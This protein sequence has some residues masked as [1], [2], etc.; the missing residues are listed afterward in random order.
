[1]PIIQS[2]LGVL[3]INR[4]NRRVGIRAIEVCFYELKTFWSFGLY[5]LRSKAGIENFINMLAMCYA[6]MKILPMSDQQFSFLMNESSLTAKNVISDAIKQE[7]FLWRFV[8]KSESYVN[9][10]EIFALLPELASSD[11]HSYAS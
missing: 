8:S 10:Q 3:K 6:S 1:M 11:K 5:M 7:L 2:I 4:H 9:S